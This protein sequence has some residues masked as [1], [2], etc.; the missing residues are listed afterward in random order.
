MQINSRNSTIVCL[1]RTNRSPVTLPQMDPVVLSGRSL[2]LIVSRAY[3]I[4]NQLKPARELGWGNM[5]S[6]ARS[7]SRVPRKPSVNYKSYFI[8]ILFFV[9]YALTP[10]KFH[11]RAFF[12]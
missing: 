10:S 6:L 1:F 2:P 5:I 7:C 4:L 3:V 9:I 11:E 8:I 12:V